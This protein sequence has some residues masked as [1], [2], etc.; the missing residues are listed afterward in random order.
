[1][2]KRKRNNMVNFR[3]DDAELKSVKVLAASLNMS[4][5]DLVKLGISVVSVSQLAELPPQVDAKAS[6]QGVHVNVAQV[7]RRMNMLE[8][9]IVKSTGEFI[10]Y[11]PDAKTS[12]DRVVPPIMLPIK[13]TG[14]GGLIH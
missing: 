10:I 3:L 13:S 14:L 12:A 1:M 4:V 5:S 9:G 11:R 2:A 8:F 6:R 7:W